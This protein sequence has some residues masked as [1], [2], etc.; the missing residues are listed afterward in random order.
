MSRLILEAE[1]TI[2]VAR[3]SRSRVLKILDAIE[4]A[5]S[6][7]ARAEKQGA[8]HIVLALPSLT[9]REAVIAGVALNLNRRERRD[10]R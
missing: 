5:R 1:R 10:S 6:S 4:D 2:A 9:L 8:T 7:I 3:R